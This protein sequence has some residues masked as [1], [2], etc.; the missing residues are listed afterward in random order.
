MH[1]DGLTCDQC[2]QSFQED[3]AFYKGPD[4]GLW[5]Q[6]CYDDY[7]TDMEFIYDSNREEGLV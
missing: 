1:T 7:I 6:Y 4:G 2:L 5:C 3:T